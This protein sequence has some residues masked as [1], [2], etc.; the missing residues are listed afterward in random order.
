MTNP[1][2]ISGPLCSEGRASPQVE[3]MQIRF[4]LRKLRPTS[5]LILSLHLRTLHLSQLCHPRSQW[6]TCN[7]PLP[8]LPISS[9]ASHCCTQERTTLLHVSLSLTGKLALQGASQGATVVALSA[10][11]SCSFYQA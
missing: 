6:M 3:A 9:K 4:P 11:L 8:H 7:L 5:R 1:L 10:C 2:P